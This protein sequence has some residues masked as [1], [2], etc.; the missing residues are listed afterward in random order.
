[1]TE[2]I[3]F[4]NLVREAFI[5]PLRSVLIID[6]QYPTWEEILNHQ[7]NDGSGDSAITTR[8]NAKDWRKQPLGALKVLRQ[9][10][11]QQPGFIIDIH[12]GVASSST[13]TMAASEEPAELA[14][15]LYQSDLLVLDYNL[16]GE[17]LGGDFAR[18]IL[19]SV[20]SNKHFNLIVIHTGEKSLDNVF[21]ECL[22]SLMSNCTEQFD[23]ALISQLQDLDQKLDE[24]EDEEKFFRSDLT[25]YFGIG[26]YAELRHPNTSPNSAI[27]TYMRSG[28]AFA[29]LSNWA[30][31]LGLA[32]KEL[33]TFLFWA[34][35]EF[36][37]PI[38]ESF[39]RDKFDS[40]KWYNG[41]DC[42]WIRT[43]RGFVTLVSKGQ[44]DL[45]GAL[46]TAL[47]N[48]KPTPSRLLSAKFRHQLN[49]IG[50]E[51]E[52]Q[53]LKKSHVFAHLY[54]EI[55]GTETS[56]SGEQQAHDA[57]MSSRRITRLKEH[58]ARQSESIAF[59]IEDEVISFGEKIVSV[60]K[61]NG[62]QFLTHYGVSLNEPTE[63]AT[64][65]A[66]YNSYISTLPLKE[67]KDQLDSGHIFKI[68]DEW[69]VCAT[70][71]CDL[72]P[73]Q[74]TIA[75][76]GSGS[77]LR[78]FMA[79]RLEKTTIDNITADHINSGTYCFVEDLPGTIIS[80]G[81]RI[82]KDDGKPTNGKVRWRT[83]LAHSNGTITD[84]TLRILIPT[85]NSDGLTSE[86]GTAQII[87]KLRYEYALN[88]IQKI[89]NSVS[90]IGLG[91]DSIRPIIQ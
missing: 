7:I 76:A 49:S 18:K 78:P 65:I 83:F 88:Y 2:G 81:L 14:N 64:A 86:E 9:F 89:G 75:F 41:A 22:I 91:F 43:G 1:M 72:Q 30:K 35:R 16:E 68:N 67:G 55:L 66:H 60:D 47:E 63:A 82:P 31:G 71:A 44:E 34:I 15:H 48:W 59:H 58:V 46:Q 61:E 42:K 74:N 70:P 19:K 69:W 57:Y 20:L 40:L 17:S 73:L 85:L 23:S 79:I 53:T 4:S 8:S 80:L 21:F 37:K 29:R 13:S 5:K 50:V 27:A 51:A 56:N 54:N 45:L 25:K 26:E 62:K 6:D 52:D 28:G 87:A 39:S 3:T 32:G 11:C 12:D 36:E 90:R 33:K 77:Q 38:L 10:R 84:K 24:L